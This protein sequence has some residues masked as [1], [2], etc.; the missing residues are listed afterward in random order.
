MTDNRNDCTAQKVITSL[1]AKKCGKAIVPA[2]K[3]HLRPALRDGVRGS[4]NTALSRTFFDRPA[5]PQRRDA[6]WLRWDPGLLPI[7]SGERQ[8]AQRRAH[9][10]HTALFRPSGGTDA[11]QPSAGHTGRNRGQPCGAAYPIRI[12]IA[13][14]S[15]SSGSDA[16]RSSVSASHMVVTSINS[17]S[18]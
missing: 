13:G 8:G 5:P 15:L 17:S 10:L 4:D 18:R 3:A 9:G 6:N 2:P 7:E 1:H 12:P 14:L 16:I 11:T